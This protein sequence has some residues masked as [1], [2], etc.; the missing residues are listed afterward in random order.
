[1][2][3]EAGIGKTTVWLAALEQAQGLGFRV[4][5]TR[6]TSAESV[7]A[8]TSLAALLD[9]LDDAAFAGLPPPQRLAIDRV[10]LRASVD[11]PVTDQRAVRRGFSL[12]VQGLAEESPVLVAIDDLQWIDPP[13][14]MIISFATRRLAGPI[15]VLATVREAPENA[16]VGASLE[17]RRPDSL[18]QIRVR[19]KSLG[20]MHAVL[21]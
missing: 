14:R 21:S 16:D 9:E 11:G 19:P 10:L 2:D 13:S 1:M 12:L 18:R 17:L 8:Y 6:A 15:G 5:S 3:G 4:L 20:A 7:L